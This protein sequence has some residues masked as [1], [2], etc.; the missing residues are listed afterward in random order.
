MMRTVGFIVPI[1]KMV[2]V[3]YEENVFPER[4]K[5]ARIVP[6]YKGKGLKTEMSSYR[7]VACLPVLSKV[8]EATW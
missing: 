6:L 4:F 5:I 7:P 2:I 1:P 3:S 8:L